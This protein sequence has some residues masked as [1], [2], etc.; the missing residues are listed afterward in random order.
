MF[1]ALGVAG[2]N[3]SDR[4]GPFCRTYGSVMGMTPA[5]IIMHNGINTG[6]VFGH[7]FDFSAMAPV[8]KALLALATC[9][10]LTT[11][12]A[13]I[14]RFLWQGLRCIRS[15]DDG[16]YADHLWTRNLHSLFR[17]YSRVWCN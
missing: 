8:Q 4:Y 13:M 17:R 9:I 11:M 6:S 10:F 12:F 3:F 7:I 14:T 5:T 15:F 16:K 1:L 2:L